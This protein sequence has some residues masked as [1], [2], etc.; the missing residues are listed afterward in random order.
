M[1]ATSLHVEILWWSVSDAKNDK[2]A[3]NKQRSG[4]DLCF[5]VLTE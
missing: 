5:S 3:G 2:K 4:R 1:H